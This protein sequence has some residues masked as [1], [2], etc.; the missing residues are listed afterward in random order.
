MC[1]VRFFALARRLSDTL[2]NIAI[3]QQPFARRSPL[4]EMQVNV[5]H[6]SPATMWSVLMLGFLAIAIAVAGGVVQVPG[7][8][9][10]DW[11][12]SA[13]SAKVWIE[14]VL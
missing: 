5:R 11:K 13:R 9:R 6:S 2:R 1:V 14:R 4:T 7:Q 3:L 10:L 8:G 12:Q